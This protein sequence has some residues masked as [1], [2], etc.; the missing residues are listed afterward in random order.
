[1]VYHLAPKQVW[2]FY[3]KLVKCARNIN[4]YDPLIDDH[5][6]I[7]TIYY[8][9]GHMEVLERSMRSNDVYVDSIIKELLDEMELAEIY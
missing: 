2:K 3:R 5:R 8:P 1:M 6:G 4:A 9:F 7:L